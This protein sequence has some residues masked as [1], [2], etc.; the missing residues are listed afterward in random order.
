VRGG[1]LETAGRV[2]GDGDAWLV[3]DGRGRG[4]RAWAW[5]WLLFPTTLVNSTKPAAWVPQRRLL[6]A[7]QYGNALQPA[8]G[9][10][11]L[12]A[13]PLVFWDKHIFDLKYVHPARRPPYCFSD[14]VRRSLAPRSGDNGLTSIA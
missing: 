1:G 4:G 5:L 13:P 6:R 11:L 14:D 9:A 2:G 7:R 12:S 8:A 10:V 3:G